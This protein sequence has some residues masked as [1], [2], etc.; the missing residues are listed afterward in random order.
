LG[1]NSRAGGRRLSPAPVWWDDKE[2]PEAAPASRF[3]LTIGRRLAEIPALSAVTAY[4]RTRKQ[5]TAAVQA[6]APRL[7]AGRLEHGEAAPGAMAVAFV[8]A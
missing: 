4:G 8:A 1:G 3:S 2:L 5:A 7:I 6:L